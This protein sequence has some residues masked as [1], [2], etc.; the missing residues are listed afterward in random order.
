MWVDSDSLRRRIG[1]RPVEYGFRGKTDA[2][3]GAFLGFWGIRSRI[4]V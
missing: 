4:G 2:V 3:L 1:Y